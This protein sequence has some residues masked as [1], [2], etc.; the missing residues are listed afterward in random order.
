MKNQVGS[1]HKPGSRRGQSK[2]LAGAGQ[3]TAPTPAAGRRASAMPMQYKVVALRECAPVAAGNLC[4]T[5][6]D[7]WAYWKKNLATDPAFNPDAECLIALLL[8]ARRR[9]KGHYLIATG[10]VDSLLVHAR[11]TF[12]AAIVGVASSI[13]LMH[14]HPTGDATPS[15]TDI[16]FTENLV[17]AGRLLNIPVTDHVIVGAKNYFSFREHGTLGPLVDGKAMALAAE[18]AGQRKSVASP[19]AGQPD[20]VQD[21]QWTDKMP[22]HFALEE[23]VDAVIALLDLM[24]IRLS[25]FLGTMPNENVRT[26]AAGIGELVGQSQARLRSSFDA[27]WDECRNIIAPNWKPAA[28]QNDGM[29]G[30]ATGPTKMGFLTAKEKAGAAAGEGGAR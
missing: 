20:G 28:G 16:S 18:G 24:Q 13:V 23:D 19:A 27:A 3:G 6:Q 5:P 12:R 29:G 4:D 22:K 10:L 15:E 26:A 8:N 11:E 30:A 14:N 9:V 25:E 7:A 21:G 17:L 1:N 2:N